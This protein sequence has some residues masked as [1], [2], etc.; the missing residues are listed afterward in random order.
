MVS[1]KDIEKGVWLTEIKIPAVLAFAL[2]CNVSIMPKR[3][4]KNKL[5][6]YILGTCI[7][8]KSINWNSVLCLNDL[9]FLAFSG[10]SEK[11]DFFCDI[12]ANVLTAISWQANDLHINFY[13]VFETIFVFLF[14]NLDYT[15]FLY[16]QL[17]YKQL[18][19]I[20]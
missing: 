10:C 1:R 20:L 11:V 17:V 14:F 13:I 7:F 18:Y 3:C 15:R 5:I 19:S 6:G 8:E 16:K 12:R 2:C 4:T 9:C